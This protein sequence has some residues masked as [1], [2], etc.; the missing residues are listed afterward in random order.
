MQ[1]VYSTPLDRWKPLG[2]FEKPFSSNFDGNGHQIYGLSIQRFDT[3]YQS[4][5]FGLFGYAENCELK[6]IILND[7]RLE[8]R[9][10]AAAGALAGYARNCHIYNC[11]VIQG[12]K[13]N[14]AS[15]SWSYC[16][17]GGLI[18]FA[19]ECLI[20]DCDVQTDLGLYQYGLNR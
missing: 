8:V 19:D 3:R 5:P 10:T 17:L 2:T 12:E 1:S 15:G 4:E 20:E 18:G 6:N 14:F 16:S 11:N 7:Y 13:E 9:Y